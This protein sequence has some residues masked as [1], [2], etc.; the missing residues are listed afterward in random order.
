MPD[1]AF[2]HKLN[3]LNLSVIKLYRQVGNNCFRVNHAFTY[4]EK[5]VILQTALRIHNNLLVTT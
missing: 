3:G 5:K 1:G 2:R 4:E